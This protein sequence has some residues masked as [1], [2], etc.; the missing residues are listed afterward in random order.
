MTYFAFEGGVGQDA[1]DGAVEISASEYLAAID[2][3]QNGMV[4]TVI[5]G[6]F[7]IVEKPSQAQPEPLP[8][9]E[10][11]RVP[12]RISRRQFFTGLWKRGFITAHE[13]LA[14]LKT[15][16]IPAA[17][18]AIIDSME[19]EEARTDAI[20]LIVGATEFY[21]DNGLVLVF[22]IVRGMSEADV[23]EFWRFCFTL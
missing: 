3:M 9:P 11:E 7:A 17:M 13:A 21:R 20:L 5:G 6:E 14:A 8:E 12:D 22:A 23:D 18:Q 10:P 19:G 15:G 4:V 16:E 2:G 1:V